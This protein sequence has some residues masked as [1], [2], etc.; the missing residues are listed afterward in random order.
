[1]VLRARRWATIAFLASIIAAGFMIILIGLDSKAVDDGRDIK[2]KYGIFDVKF[3]ILAAQLA[4]A[5]ITFV[6]LVLFILIYLI[7]L[8]LR[9]KVQ[10]AVFHGG[11]PH[12]QLRH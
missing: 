3:K 8:C 1:M 12:P 2:N 6:L 4:L 10:P 7:V 9:P 11:Y 5:V